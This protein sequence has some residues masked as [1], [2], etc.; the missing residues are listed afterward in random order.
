MISNLL[1]TCLFN[2]STGWLIFFKGNS[3]FRIQLLLLQIRDISLDDRHYVFSHN[4]KYPFI[5]I[6]ISSPYTFQL[7]NELECTA[8]LCPLC[9]QPTIP[10]SQVFS[11]HDRKKWQ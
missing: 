7:L 8:E 11:A 6:A 3:R 2:E 9:T 5:A 10:P 4:A 1:I